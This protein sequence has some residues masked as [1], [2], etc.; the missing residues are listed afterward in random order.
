MAFLLS[1][2]IWNLLVRCRNPE[3]RVAKGQKVKGNVVHNVQL[4]PPASMQGKHKGCEESSAPFQKHTSHACARFKSRIIDRP[5]LSR[6]ADAQINA[7]IANNYMQALVKD[8]S[9]P[10]MF[11]SLTPSRVVVKA[12]IVAR[13]PAPADITTSTGSIQSLHRGT[14]I[15]HLWSCEWP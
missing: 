5:P 6:T 15:W 14:T 1:N 4:A 7:C 12:V 2:R 13:V 3:R 10:A 8:Q 11:P 9:E